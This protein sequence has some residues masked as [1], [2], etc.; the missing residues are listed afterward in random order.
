MATQVVQHLKPAFQ[1]RG[2]GLADPNIDLELKHPYVPYEIFT[3]SYAKSAVFAAGDLV[4][5]KK[6][7]GG[8]DVEI[9]RQA[10]VAQFFY[11]ELDMVLQHEESLR[12]IT[13][14]GPIVLGQ[15]HEVT[16]GWAERTENQ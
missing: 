4:I 1:S 2:A 9:F 13:T 14:A 15:S 10:A 12:V 6:Q 16:I 3:V 5:Y 7:F 11:K 8:I